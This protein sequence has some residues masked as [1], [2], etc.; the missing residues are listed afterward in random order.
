MVSQLRARQPAVT[1]RSLFGSFVAHGTLIGLLYLGF[2]STSKADAPSQPPIAITLPATSV[3][4]G[5]IPTITP[6]GDL[7]VRARQT[8]TPQPSARTSPKPQVTPTP[9]KRVTS[10]PTRR[11]WA[12]PIPSI[13]PVVPA[14]NEAERAEFQVMRSIPYFARMSDDEL[15]QQRIPPGMR[16]WQEV[17]LMGK[18]LDA[19]NWLFL[20]PE[21][22]RRSDVS[23][24][25]A[26]P[27]PSNLIPENWPS[28]I[29]SRDPDGSETVR[30][31]VT[32]GWLVARWQAGAS[33]VT[34]SLEIA[35]ADTPRVVYEV[36]LG[37]DVTQLAEAIAR[38]YLQAITSPA[39]TPIQASPTPSQSPP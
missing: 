19:L 9:T 12:T 25:P 14:V 23:P 15:R 28:P 38:G 34:V 37:E 16:S 11:V 33:V 26:S 24:A 3:R 22:V 39:P 13:R 35:N 18:R 6:R 1:G 7:P 36:P 2:G 20:P 17:V 8:P 31:A 4:P 29:A 10:R 32:E 5:P 30:F 21:T 27:L